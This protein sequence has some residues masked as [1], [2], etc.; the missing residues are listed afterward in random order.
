MESKP[1][2]SHPEGYIPT[3]SSATSRA[4]LHCCCGQ[5]DCVFLQHNHDA[6]EGLEKDLETAAR[7]GQ[8]RFLTCCRDPR[9]ACLGGCWAV[10]VID[11][12]HV[13]YLA[14][15]VVYCR[16]IFGCTEVVH[17]LY[18]IYIACWGWRFFLSI[19]WPYTLCANQG[20]PRVSLSWPR[21]TSSPRFY[22]AVLS[23]YAL[24]LYRQGL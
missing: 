1:G 10:M 24:L 9:L 5:K 12:S 13:W 20:S 4:D 19:L 22:P 7:L 2:T 15:V 17:T 8:V 14:I 11:L 18:L 16:S 21:N 3:H 6:L 23:V